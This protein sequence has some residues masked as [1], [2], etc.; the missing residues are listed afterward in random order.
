MDEPGKIS[1]LLKMITDRIEALVTRELSLDVDLVRLTA[2]QGRVLFYLSTRVDEAVSQKEVEQYIGVSH[3]TVRGIIRRL[4]EKDLVRTAF[5]HEDKRV[6]NV[7]LTDRSR[8]ILQE[9]GKCIDEIEEILT[10]GFSK[11]DQVLLKEFLQRVY[12]NAKHR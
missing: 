3:T 4:K 6:K 10:E 11:A 12:T 1:F 2:A 7:Y 8:S 9:V 5:D